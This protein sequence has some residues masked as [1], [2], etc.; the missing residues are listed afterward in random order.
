M[1]LHALY[2]DV[3]IGA[4]RVRRPRRNLA[5]KCLESMAT[6]A[7]PVITPL[8]APRLT[9]RLS[10]SRSYCHGHLSGATFKDRYSLTATRTMTKKMN[11]DFR[12]ADQLS[13]AVL[14]ASMKAPARNPGN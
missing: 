1:E 5:L 11:A 6:I 2:L 10:S 3:I 14:D 7:N 13:G 12:I 9:L 8:A 4:Y